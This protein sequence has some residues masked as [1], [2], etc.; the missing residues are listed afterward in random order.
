MRDAILCSVPQ[1]MG[2][3]GHHGNPNSPAYSEST[4]DH[5]GYA[6]YVPPLNPL[7]EGLY[8]EYLVPTVVV[9]I[10]YGTCI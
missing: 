9:I 4:A 2:D 10:S 7:L 3:I 8:A 5:T 6:S 1:T